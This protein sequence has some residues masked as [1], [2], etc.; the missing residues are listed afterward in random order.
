M[1]RCLKSCAAYQ[2]PGSRPFDKPRGQLRHHTV[3][4]IQALSA[5]KHRLVLLAKL[6]QRIQW[7]IFKKSINYFHWRK[8]NMIN[9][10]KERNKNI[11]LLVMWMNGNNRTVLTL[12]KV[13]DKL[14]KRTKLMHS[15]WNVACNWKKRPTSSLKLLNSLRQSFIAKRINLA[16][17]IVERWTALITAAWRHG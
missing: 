8:V 5:G 15:H 12:V 17:G 11:S 6:D 13:A 16:L 7:T 3:Y 14:G 10:K 2:R 4:P 9:W 1:R